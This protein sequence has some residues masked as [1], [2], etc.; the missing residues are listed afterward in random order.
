MKQKNIILFL[1]FWTVSLLIYQLFFRIDRLHK[2]YWGGDIHFGKK[3]CGKERL[4]L[5]PWESKVYIKNIQ[6]QAPIGCEFVGITYDF[7]CD[8]G[9]DCMDYGYKIARD[10]TASDGSLIIPVFERRKVMNKLL[11]RDIRFAE[12]Y[13]LEINDYVLAQD[14]I[15]HRNPSSNTIYVSA[16]K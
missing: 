16:K 1:A 14:W 10:Y 5:W 13:G 4:L 2:G 7:F 15:K 8:L 9:T 6:N 3:E 11:M 12:G